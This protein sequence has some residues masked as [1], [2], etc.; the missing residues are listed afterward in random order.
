MTVAADPVSPGLAGQPGHALGL[1]GR[2][3]ADPV[4]RMWHL[5]RVP[6]LRLALAAG[7][8][9]MSLACAVGLLAT[10]AWLISRASQ[11]PPILH[12]QVAI[13]AVRAFG[14]SRGVF[15]YAER[16]VGH[17]SA[18]RS[19]T[20][21]RSAVFTRLER[22]SPAGLGQYRR[23]DLL[24]RLVGDVDSSV[25]L[26]VRVFLPMIAAAVVA[27]ATVGLAW[28]LLPA[29]GVVLA[30]MVVVA[31][32]V[33]P[34]LA[35]AV[36]GSSER[37][38]AGA[39]AQLSAEIVAGLRASADLVAYGATGA[40]MTRIAAAD[41]E[42]ERLARRSATAAGLGSALTVGATGF[43]VVACLAFGVQAVRAGAL[44]GVALAVV[45]L[46]PLALAEVLSGLP[47]AR[48]AR[49]RVAGA[50]GRIF[51]VIDSA[52]PVSDPPG[53]GQPLRADA[54]GPSGSRTLVTSGAAARYP[55]AS[56]DA[57]TA[58]DLRLTGSRRVALIGPSG[59]GKSTLALLLVR[60]L[61]PAAGRIDLDG[62]DVTTLSQDQVRSVVGLMTQD[63]HIFDTTI[64][65]NIHLADRSATAVQVAEAAVRA[66]LGQWLAELPGG[67]NTRVGAHGG[68]VSGGQ[69]QRIALARTLLA[70]RPVQLLDEPGEHLEAELA[71]RL[72]A[73]ILADQA[74][75][76]LLITHRL[77]PTLDC[78]EVV[79][80]ESGH[81]VERGS[82]ARLVAARGAYW[83]M[84]ARERG[85][86]AAVGRAEV[87]R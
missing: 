67:L 1:G 26:Q 46:L 38:M 18:L 71:D 11:Q 50:A 66:G 42:V 39:Q 81:V 17:D 65:E 14:I 28:S 75:P 48:L 34:A 32:L 23:G 82:P 87:Q 3:R 68:A 25:D 29:A 51:E 19:L 55:G 27:A 30:L 56:A 37:A 74:R 54:A 62:A 83:A 86:E 12:L 80:L 73:D 72:L 24:A 79:V 4:W 33:A 21:I 47:A 8:A 58:I 70:A 45:A 5:A 57:L 6:R 69:R 41:A 44:D 59:S 52:D 43:S 84:L 40:A 15:R 16:V 35:V 2:R 64:E 31:A 7:A 63:A 76:T 13:V 53:G 10:S 9:S 61:D 20:N 36:A 85:D 77:G 22:L 49:S 60:F 78:D